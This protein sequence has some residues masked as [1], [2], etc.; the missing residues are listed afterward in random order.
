MEKIK[1]M[2]YGIVPTPRGISSTVTK[3]KQPIHRRK[4]FFF[5]VVVVKTNILLHIPI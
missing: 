2:R 3:K 4:H 5:V 1:Q